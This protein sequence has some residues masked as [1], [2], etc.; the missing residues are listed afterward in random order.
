MAKNYEFR[1]D[2]PQVS[3]LSKL[4]LTQL[5]RQAL[6]KWTLYA[7]FLLVL[8]LLQDVVLARFRLFEA[9]TELVPCAIFLI[10]IMEGS[11]AGSLF[12]LISACLYVFSGSAAGP[13]SLI[14][15]TALAI[16]VC[17][18]R[19]GYLQKGFAAAMLCTG[20]A[21]IVYEAAIFAIGLVTGLTIPARFIGFAITAG[22]TILTA[23][24]LYPIILSIGS[25]GGDTWKE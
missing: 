8:S 10:C 19:Q 20:F 12:S 21:V 7:L 17:I 3:W 5:Q 11:H 23:P 16:F 25:I 4:H 14:L 2:K 24:I 22:L 13:Y 1:P 15:I 9:T 18:F 6:L